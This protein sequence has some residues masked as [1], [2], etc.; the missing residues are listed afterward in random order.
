MILRTQEEIM[1]GWPENSVPLVSISCITY[2]HAPYIR[3]C[4]DGFLMQKTT[5]SFEIL[6]HDDA[7]P[8]GTAD[9]IREYEKKYPLL[10]KPIYQTENQYSQGKTSVSA[11]WN[12]PRAKGKYIALCEGDDYWIDENKLQMQADFL[13]K[14]P[15]YGM[16]YTNFNILNQSTDTIENDLF[17]TNLEK[18]KAEY[19]LEDWIFMA[20]YIAP[21]SWVFRRNLYGKIPSI[22]TL[23]GSFVMVAAF[24]HETKLKCFKNNTTCV[25][26]IL[27][28]SAAHSKDIKRIYARNKSLIDTKISLIDL[29]GLSDEL[30]FK[31]EQKYYHSNFKMI[32][33]CK[34]YEELKKIFSLI[35]NKNLQEKIITKMSKIKFLHR[36]ISFV[37]AI[38]WRYDGYRKE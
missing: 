9:I 27:N 7:S 10:I 14:N 19:N 35:E 28:E 34:S 32:A 6:I 22:K 29:Y 8:D 16:C 25:Y 33:A 30:R 26:R 4:L 11:T 5:F 20:G 21:M 36:I 37:Y 23:D 15:E 17:N 24:I 1:K 2:N 3:Q 38:Y 31:C 18:Y 12:F 13:E